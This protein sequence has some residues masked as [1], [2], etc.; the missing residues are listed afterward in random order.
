VSLTNVEILVVGVD[1]PA[2]VVED[3]LVRLVPTETPGYASDKRNLGMSLAQGDIF[4]F[5][6]DDCLPQPDWLA[7]HL[8][9]HAQGEDIV[10]GAITFKTDHYL[11][12]AD[13]VSAFHDL[14]PF[15][16]AGGRP[17][18]TTSNL[19]VNRS[20]V[21]K[22]GKMTPGKNRAE[23]LEWTARFRKFGYRL[24]FEPS[25]IIVHQPAR[26][27]FSA[28]WQHWVNDAPDTLRVR[29]EYA[30]LLDTPSLAR[31][32]SVFLWGALP[33]AMWATA[34]TFSH[35]QTLRL[36]GHTLPLV[37]LTKLIWCWGASRGF[38]ARKS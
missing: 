5:L 29:L 13:N 32:R 9:R 25:A 8:A 12:L 31:H 16:K 19:S 6:D 38:K 37:Y 35:S 30:E 11:Q 15:T 24:Y 34:R 4:F 23:D 22:A 2:L 14:L 26:N 3:E 7:Q 36:Y 20:V 17:Y 10:G 33:A 27:S 18:L 28:L 21:E 1:A